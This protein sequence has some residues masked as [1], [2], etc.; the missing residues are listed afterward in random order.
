VV[1]ARLLSKASDFLFT[2]DPQGQRLLTVSR[3]AM[4]LLLLACLAT[5]VLAVRS[6][7][8]DEQVRHT[9]DVRTGAR[10]IL[11]DIQA[12]VL[13]ERAFLLT[14]DRAKL[15]KDF[16]ASLDRIVNAATALSND[17]ADNPAQVT[18]LET[19]S[20][21]IADLSRT[22]IETV[23]LM[24]SGRN[25]EAVAVVRSDKVQH[26]LDSLRKQLDEIVG[27]E[28]SLLAAR[29]R[30]AALLENVFLW[31][32]G[33]SLAVALALSIGL[34]GATRHFVTSLQQHADELKAEI[35]R[36]ENT[37]ATLR[38][39]QKM[40]AVGQLSGG[41][42]HD[43]N[44]LLTIILGNIEMIKRRLANAVPTEAAAKIEK[45][46]DMAQQAGRNAA[47]L[48]HRLLAFA[49]RQPLEPKRVDCNKLVTDMTDMLRRSIGEA[50]DFEAVL[51]AGIWPALVDPNQLESALLN[52][53]VNAQ[54]AMP[55]G[56]RLTIETANTFLDEA[57][58]SRFG[59]VTQGQYVMI[60]VADTGT[61]IAPDV[62]ENV[63]EPF[64]TTK[65]VGV[66]TGLGLSMV[67]GFMKQSG[68]HVRI[69]SE[70]GHGTTVKLY[71]PRYVAAT[72]GGS[73]HPVGAEREHAPLARAL[74]GQTILIVE[75]NDGVRDYAREI[76]SD[77][78]YSIHEAV[79]A[80]DALDIVKSGIPLDL[81]FTDVVLPG[82]KSGR[83]LSDEV[84]Q[85]R[86]SLP[87]LFT[88]G[89]T[90]NAIVHHGRLDPGVQLIGKP[91]TQ[92]D[93]ANRIRRLLETAL[94]ARES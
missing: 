58:A 62:L 83:Q 54:H 82:G 85:L 89:Y 35:S 64:F 28:E 65:P 47:K 94:K 21:D 4:G 63:F 23:A 25:A 32:I 74:G 46:I 55:N 40:E 75:D 91:Y 7:Q 36:R 13:K 2:N 81:L 34:Q 52:L 53:A 78:G 59:D 41:I 22:L 90:Q 50:I 20:Q 11:R 26:L 51:G 30:D 44:N 72:S 8:A 70:V 66:G 77:L 92:H 12:A 61:G 27:V 39:I 79:N 16:Q 15:G 67:H 73:V 88:T 45:H 56:G 1:L 3:L 87:V 5:G 29:D 33:T 17:V 42:A 10:N 19:V 76:L 38:Q 80:D 9:L 49:R 84:A 43:F 37:E 48:T 24:D 18:R 86:P 57:Y 31:V 68:G 14:L 69:Y 71:L 93:L 60:S 6:K